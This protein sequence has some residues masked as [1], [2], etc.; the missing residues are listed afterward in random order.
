MVKT[1]RRNNAS[2]TSRRSR[3]NTRV[4]R[5]NNNSKRKS[6]KVRHRKR[7]GNGDYP[8]LTPFSRELVVNTLKNKEDIELFSKIEAKV[9]KELVETEGFSPHSELTKEQFKYVMIL[10]KYFIQKCQDNPG[11]KEEC[12]KILE[13]LKKPIDGL[14]PQILDEHNKKTGLYNQLTEDSAHHHYKVLGKLI[15]LIETYIIITEA[16]KRI[17]TLQQEINSYK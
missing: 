9:E 2:K 1:K 7:G 4:Q 3:R 13:H 11:T 15:S 10:L 14:Y 5:N 16:E 8:N 6:N 17:A 12:D